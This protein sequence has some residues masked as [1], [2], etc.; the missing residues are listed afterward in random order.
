M[1]TQKLNQL[2][3]ENFAK[4]LKNVNLAN[5]ND[6]TNFLKKINFDDK[7]NN[8]NTK[9]ISDITKYLKVKNKLGVPEKKVKL[10]S[11]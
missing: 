4:I 8:I 6:I 1:T 10:I 5:K 11:V 3:K 9:D 7:L 2:T